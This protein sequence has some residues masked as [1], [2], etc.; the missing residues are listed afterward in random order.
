MRPSDTELGETIYE[1]FECGHRITQQEFRE[2]PHC[3]GT[4]KHLGR[5]RDL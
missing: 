4:L 1:C 2:C 5:P 3:G